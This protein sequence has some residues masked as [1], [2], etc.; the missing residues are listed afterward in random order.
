MKFERN[1]GNLVFEWKG[2]DRPNDMSLSNRVGN[3]ETE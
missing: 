1:W 2:S 3:I